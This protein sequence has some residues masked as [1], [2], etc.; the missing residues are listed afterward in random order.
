MGLA[1]FND[2]IDSQQGMLQAIQ[3]PVLLTTSKA[4]LTI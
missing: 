4:A 2:T 1:V 3:E